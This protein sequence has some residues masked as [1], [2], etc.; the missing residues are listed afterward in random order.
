MEREL[1][2][3][4]EGAG[5]RE[6]NFFF[7]AADAASWYMCEVLVFQAEKEESKCEDLS[8]GGDGR[9]FTFIGGR[10]VGGRCKS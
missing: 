10:A 7:T 3:R 8:N 9:V 2:N 5:G 6:H 1:F 4:M